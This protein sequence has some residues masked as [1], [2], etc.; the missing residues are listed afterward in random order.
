MPTSRSRAALAAAEHRPMSCT[1]IAMR[2]G[3]LVMA[4]VCGCGRIGFDGPSATSCV[5]LAPSC[6]PAANLNCCDS[7]IVP[8]G[9][10]Y[11]GLDLATD[12]MFTDM[13]DPATVS[14]F[15]LDRYEVTV[16]RFRQFVNAGMGTQQN[17]PVAGA[18]AHPN[19]ANSG[20]DPMWNGSLLADTTAL[21]AAVSCGYEQTWTDMPGRNDNL[22][23]VCVDWYEAMAFCVWDGGFL[24]SEAEWH[25]AASGGAAQRAF[26]WSS[27][28][29]DLTIDC[30][31][32][33]YNPPPPCIGAG[34]NTVGAASPAGDGMWGQADLAGNA[35]EW[36]LDWYA[37]YTTPCADCANVSGGGSRAFRG[38]SFEDP[39]THVRAAQRDLNAPAFRQ[40]NLGVRCART[41]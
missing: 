26:P 7:P 25:Y 18:G 14:T 33:D 4:V 21:V 1:I 39:A 20:W 13:A 9:T 10:F 17:P 34:I 24:P 41:P 27:P 38:G 19:I 29:G 22:P 37:A 36:V 31:H 5:T 6:G 32:A 3:M 11:R 30:N 35:W 8:G 28:A 12:G 16:G 23:I 2:A 40:N 15:S